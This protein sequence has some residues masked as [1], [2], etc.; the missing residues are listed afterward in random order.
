MGSVC[1]LLCNRTIVHVYIP[2]NVL[3]KF[4][5]AATAGSAEIE[6]EGAATEVGPYVE[7]EGGWLFVTVIG[8]VA[9]IREN[10]GPFM[11]I[12]GPNPTFIL[13]QTASIF[14]DVLTAVKVCALA[15]KDKLLTWNQ[16]F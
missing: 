1:E 5:P 15:S 10:P 8:F 4:G 16:A 12:S 7:D 14:T 6:A 2:S 9:D 13:S 3:S 11:F